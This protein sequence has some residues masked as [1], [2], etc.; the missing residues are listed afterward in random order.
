MLV[1]MPKKQ[2]IEVEKVSGIFLPQNLYETFN[3][4][5]TEEVEFAD[6]V[7]LGKLIGVI[8]LILTTEEEI[9]PQINM[10][11]KVRTKYIEKIKK[12]LVDLAIPYD[13]EVIVI[14]SI[15]LNNECN[16]VVSANAYRIKLKG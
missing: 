9:L 15:S 3:P 13:A 4:K 16:I 14:K 2:G 6:N 12:H 1:P 7:A 5:K 10:A 8:N 11:Q